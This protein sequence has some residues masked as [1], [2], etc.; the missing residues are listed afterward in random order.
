MPKVLIDQ[1]SC[2]GSG[3]CMA[4]CSE[5]FEVVN[6]VSQV[7]EKYRDDNLTEGTVPEE[8]ECVHKAEEKCPFNAILV[9]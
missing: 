3:N 1:E 2:S 9:K 6:G 5:V 4:L 7:V 8:V